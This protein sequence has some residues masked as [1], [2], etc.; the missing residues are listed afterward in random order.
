[1]KHFCLIVVIYWGL[2]PSVLANNEVD[3]LIT[4]KNN[5]SDPNGVLQTW[6]A[7]NATPCLWKQVTCDQNSVTKIYLGDASLSGVLSPQIGQLKNLVVLE[8]YGNDISGPIPSEIGN[9]AKLQKLDL[10]FN[11]FSGQIPSSLGNLLR[12]QYLRLNNNSLSGDIPAS[13]TA[14]S[15]L[16]VLDLST[17]DLSGEVPSNGSFLHF[18]PLSFANNPSLQ[19]KS[20][21]SPCFLPYVKCNNIFP[22][23]APE[24]PSPAPA[25]ALPPPS[26]NSP[27]HAVIGLISV[28]GAVTVGFASFGFW[29]FLYRRRQ[30]Y[31]DNIFGEHCTV[32][33]VMLEFLRC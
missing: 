1:M 6:N 28:I 12:L 16:Q 10:Y 17:N 14:L 26:A 24:P 25:P 33:C 9:L 18:T 11:N 22:E 7:S 15:D 20:V 3:A 19:G 29:W 27:S 4:V 2:Y 32:Q 23:P 8:F 30:K 21:E 31:S 5:L 13:L